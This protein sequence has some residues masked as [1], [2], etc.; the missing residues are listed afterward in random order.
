MF[1]ACC[2]HQRTNVVQGHM[3]G[4]PNDTRVS[5]MFSDESKKPL[6]IRVCKNE[7]NNS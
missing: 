7:I 1:P 3:N 5:H 2:F 6:N 4:A